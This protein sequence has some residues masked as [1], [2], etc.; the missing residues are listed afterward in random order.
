MHPPGQSP[1]DI[2]RPVTSN[3]SAAAEVYA[4]CEF[5]HLRYVYEHLHSFWIW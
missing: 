1:F 3:G 5:R 4:H 2:R